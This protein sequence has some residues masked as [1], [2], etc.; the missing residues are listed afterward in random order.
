MS[1]LRGRHRAA[2]AL[3]DT[4]S[5]LVFQLS[6]LYL[7]F[8]YT[9]VLGLS[10]AAAG[11]VFVIARVW[12]AVNNP[13][14]GYLVDHTQARGGNTRVYLRWVPLPLAAA[15]VLL[16]FCPP[17]F[18]ADGRFAWAL[19]TYVV[20]SMLFTMVNIPYSAMTAQLT[21]DPR[22]RTALTS[23]RMIGMLAAVVVVS[24]ATEP[25]VSSFADPAQGWLVVAAVYGLLAFGF[26]E[27][28][29]R[30]TRRLP[31][32]AQP[33][34]AYR[35]RDVFRVIARNKPALVVVVT[36]FF[37]ASAEYIRESSVV[38]YVTYNMGDASLISLFLGI[39]VLS[40]VAGNLIIPWLADRWDKAG[41]FAAGVVLACVSSLAFQFVPYD[42]TAWIFALAAVSSLG[43]SVVSTMGWAMLPD[44]VEYGEWATGIR[45]EG[46]LYAVFSFSQKLATAVGGGV[47]AWILAASGYQSGA[48]SQE[49]GA[50]AGIASTLGVLPLGFLLLSLG[51]VV[52]Y[53]LDRRTFGTLQGQLAQRRAEGTK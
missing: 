37:G 26:F 28:C 51:S 53:R 49:A 27:V 1:E 7:L 19:G 52:F 40:M 44:T 48:P 18:T 23:A 20:W 3:G 34:E 17:G 22:E 32:A 47:V 2:Y 13:I 14:M 24:V 38:Y 46:I 42:Q 9:D 10:P 11:L 30:G 29:L 5:N 16:F 6:L 50:L 43:F 25:L 45:S 21:G 15:T 36:F 33:A 4:A 12:D 31:L 41:T 39:V 35:L 8:Y